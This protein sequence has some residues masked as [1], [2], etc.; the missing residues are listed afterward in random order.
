MQQAW[1]KCPQ[2]HETAIII[3][4]LQGAEAAGVERLFQGGH[5]SDRENDDTGEGFAP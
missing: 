1:I 4:L 5:R 2:S 3:N